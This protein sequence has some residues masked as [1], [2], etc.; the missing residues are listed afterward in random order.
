MIF[1]NYLYILEEI[2][3]K[4]GNSKRKASGLWN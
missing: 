2:L 4:S 1:N 3:W